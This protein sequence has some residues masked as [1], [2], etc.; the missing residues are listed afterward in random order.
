MEAESKLFY[1][2][3]GTWWAVL[4]TDN[5]VAGVFLYRLNNN[6]WQQ[7]TK[8]PQSDPWMKADVLYDSAHSKLYVA[9]RDSKSLTGNPRVS[10]LYVYGY[11]SGGG[12]NR[13]SGPTKITTDNPR[14][15]TITLDSQGRLWT[16]YETGGHIIV[17]HTQPG[18]TSFSY[19][20]I[21]WS[22]I[23]S[24]DTSVVASFGTGSSGFKVG[25]L[26][27]DTITE[28]YMFAWRNDSAPLSSA[29]NIETVY[30]N[31][32]GGCPTATTTA[33]ANYHISL[34]TNGDDVYAAVKLMS[35]NSTNPLDPMI[36][37]V[38]R[39]PNGAWTAT[40]V[41]YKKQNAS[42]Q[43]LLLAPAQNRAYVIAESPKS[44]LF[45]WEGSLSSL[46]FNPN[47]YAQWAIPNQNQHEDPTSTK[48]PLGADGS[49]VVESS[50]G[51]INQYWLN[52]FSAL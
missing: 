43:V 6:Q 50:Q 32:V 27:D 15:L 48:Q 13:Q 23:A 35:Q 29:W 46:T 20:N 11:G 30:G 37:V 19:S 1:T 5:P 52:G 47:A 44:G 12:W 40:T 7:I 38:H 18:S 49:G 14:N 51:L 16:T 3:D 21:P 34:K 26:W 17:G 28:R 10:E 36:V 2:P 4:G 41:S 9:L 39:D 22:S 31:G 45:V 42:R 25:V 24:N 33:C 8:L